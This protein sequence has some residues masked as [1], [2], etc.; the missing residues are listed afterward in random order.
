MSLIPCLLGGLLMWF[1]MLKSGV[2]ATVAG[3][4]MAFAIPFSAQ[5]DD[6]ASPSHMLEH[7]LHK[8]VAFVIVPI[9]ALANTAILLAPDFLASVAS[10][11]C[12]ALAKRQ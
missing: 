1:L 11:G 10:C 3:V 12:R 2:H 4:M 7:S 5:D 9:F 6:K 8:T